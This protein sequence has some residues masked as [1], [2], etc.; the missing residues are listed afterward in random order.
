MNDF[1]GQGQNEG[2]VDLPAFERQQ[3]DVAPGIPGN[4]AI[5]ELIGFGPIKIKTEIGKARSPSH[6]VH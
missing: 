2:K 3:I 4:D 6:R 1:M 5:G